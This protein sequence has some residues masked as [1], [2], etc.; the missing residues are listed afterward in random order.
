MLGLAR[1][2]DGDDVG[3]LER[4]LQAPFASEATDELVIA[5]ALAGDHLQR[6]PAT[7]LAVPG[8]VDGRHPATAEDSLDD[9]AAHHCS[10]LKRHE[11]RTRIQ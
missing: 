6:D 2:E 1:L 4:R 7:V 5:D 9:V 11:Y 3:V 10:R 8:A